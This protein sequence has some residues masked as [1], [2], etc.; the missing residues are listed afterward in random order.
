MAADA[1]TKEDSGR[2]NLVLTDLL[3]KGIMILV[4]EDG[5]LSERSLTILKSRSRR[6]SQE[7][8]LKVS[9]DE[10]EPEKR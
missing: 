6:A 5:H 3:S 1:L 8:L 4:D 9:V 7:A 2:G 10:M